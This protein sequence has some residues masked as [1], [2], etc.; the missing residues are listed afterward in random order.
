MRE[1]I[2]WKRSGWL[3]GTDVYKA[4]G[5]RVCAAAGWNSSKGNVMLVDRSMGYVRH[6]YLIDGIREDMKLL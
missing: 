5:L 3:G 2:T 4:G 6:L 1:D